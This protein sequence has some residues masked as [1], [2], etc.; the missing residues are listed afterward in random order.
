[1]LKKN[2]NKKKIKQ[3]RRKKTL[4]YMKDQ[5]DRYQKFSLKI[6]NKS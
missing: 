4:K 5:I 1:M 6:S 2:Y 3:I